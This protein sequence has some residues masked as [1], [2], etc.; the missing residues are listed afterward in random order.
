[1]ISHSVKSR[2]ILF[3]LLAGMFFFKSSAYATEFKDSDYRRMCYALCW[4]D[5]EPIFGNDWSSI[6]NCI[7][8]R[9]LKPLF[10]LNPKLTRKTPT[11]QA[12]ILAEFTAILDKCENV[13]CLERYDYEIVR[14][15]D[16]TY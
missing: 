16:L 9:C 14:K 2:A 13:G 8:S 12:Q 4:D 3:A 10:C 15:Y 7:Q 6:K 1:M 11:E 5:Y